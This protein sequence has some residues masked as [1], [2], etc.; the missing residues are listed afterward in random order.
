MLSLLAR[1]LALVVGLLFHPIRLFRWS[2]AA[3]P[4]GWIALELEGTIEDIPAPQR[5]WE[6]RKRKPVSLHSLGELARLM[7]E[8]PRVRGLVVTIRDVRFGM[9]TATSLRKIFARIREAERGVVVYLPYGGDTKE[10]YLAFAGSDVVVGPQATLSPLG[11][12]VTA[13]YVSQALA[14]LGVV[15]EVFARGRYKSA[16]ESLVLDSMSEPQREQLG[17][18]VESNYRALVAAIAAGRGT[19]EKKAA[20]LIDGA[21]YLGTEAVRVGLADAVAYDDGL[22]ERVVPGCKALVPAARYLRRRRMRLPSLRSPGVIGVVRIHGAI[23]QSGRAPWMSASDERVM[24][25]IRIARESKR[26]LGVVL[27]IDSPGGSA[28]ASDRMHHELVRLAKEKPLIACMSNVAAS[29]GYYVAA[30][31]HAIVAQPTTITGSIGVVAARLA[32]DPLL[33]KLGVKSEIVKRGARADFMQSTRQLTTDEREVMEVELDAVYRAF[34]AVVA[35]GRKKTTEEVDALAQGRVWSG[36]DAHARGLIDELGG[37][38]RALDLVRAR[39][40]K[41]GEKAEPAV[42]QVRRGRTSQQE[43][44]L[45]RAAAAFGWLSDD[46]VVLEMLA[47][48]RGRERVL[49]WADLGGLG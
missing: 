40:G 45:G 25:A 5:L 35:E 13:Q 28:L 17:A 38:D 33:A 6:R 31:A 34:V 4:S 9:A 20:E 43:R 37:F 47:L 3:L 44:D 23:V 41:A 14:K 12:A 24:T 26:V 22:L 32:I 49:L 27:H 36:A 7:A 16:G 2:R 8:D 1:L 42:I 19:D 48:A 18:L 29:G 21:P 39:I 30:A 10:C 46:V 15:P 11:F